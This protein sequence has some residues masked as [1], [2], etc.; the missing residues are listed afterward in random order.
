MTRLF[1]LLIICFG[2]L[3]CSEQGP[4]IALWIDIPE[5]VPVPGAVDT[6]RISISS[7]SPDDRVCEEASETVE[8]SSKGDF[9]L[10]IL[11]E[12]GSIYTKNVVYE[13][14]GFH[15]EEPAVEGIVGF[16]SWPSE[17]IKD[18]RLTLYRGC[19]NFE[20]PCPD[21]QHCVEGEDGGLCITTNLPDE[22]EYPENTTQ[23]SCLF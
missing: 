12:R 9:P 8:L 6:L 18:V 19:F 2:S 1:A 4:A 3:G 7:S 23:T 11:L 22:F 21:N 16:T 13:V 10:Y 14:E 15:V 20:T 5:G 17:G